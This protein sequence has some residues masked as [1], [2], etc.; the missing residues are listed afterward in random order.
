[1]GEVTDT[2]K[3][4]ALFM[5]DQLQG[6]RQ[7]VMYRSWLVE[8]S[9]Q[10]LSIRYFYFWP[11]YEQTAVN[12]LVFISLAPIVSGMTWAGVKIALKEA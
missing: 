10:A 1:M 5:L 2:E 9:F 8:M 7:A 11:E 4:T 6:C 3:E 12:W